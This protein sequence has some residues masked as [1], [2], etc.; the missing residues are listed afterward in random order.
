MLEAAVAFVVLFLSVTIGR[1]FSPSTREEYA[2]DAG[3]RRVSIVIV[4]AC[5][6]VALYCLVRLIHWAWITPMPYVSS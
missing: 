6:A 2:D 5:A 4:W 3:E 1:I